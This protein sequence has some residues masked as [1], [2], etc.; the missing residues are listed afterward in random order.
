MKLRYEPGLIIAAIDAAILL[1][2][3]YGVPVSKPQM[4]AIMGVVLALSAFIVRGKTRTQA[5]LDAEAH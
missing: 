1:A 4:V 3:S 5:S 2:I